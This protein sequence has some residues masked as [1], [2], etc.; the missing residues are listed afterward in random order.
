MYLLSNCYNNTIK[1]EIGSCW[2]GLVFY[3]MQV[4][5]ATSIHLCQL[6]IC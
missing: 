3:D 5:R 1:Q 2:N 6:P 4:K